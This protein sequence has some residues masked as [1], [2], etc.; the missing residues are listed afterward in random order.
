MFIQE[1]QKM[2][3][4]RG[5]KLLSVLLSLT[6]MLSLLP[7]VSLTALAATANTVYVNAAG[8]EQPAVNA[9]VLESSIKEWS[10]GWYVV[11]S[12]G[13]TISDNI[14]VSGEVNLILTDGTTLTASGGI[15]VQSGTLTIYGQSEG[16]GALNANIGENGMPDAPINGRQGSITI[17]GGKVS[18]TST[19][20]TGINAEQ[21][22]TIN[23]GEV[24]ATGYQGIG[25]S[26]DTIITIN[27]GTVQATGTSGNGISVQLRSLYP[28]RI[29]R[30]RRR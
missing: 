2:K 22:L 9:T 19:M 11:P 20:A 21:S 28:R 15:E 7:V 18:A 17:N 24:T 10:A 14:A 30:L 26:S 5:T 25:G 16:T 4:K 3:H 29:L 6:L 8:E 1:V 27:G 12:N 13:V 23:G